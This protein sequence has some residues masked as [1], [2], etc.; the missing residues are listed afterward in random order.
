[1][2]LCSWSVAI[3]T[4]LPFVSNLYPSAPPGWS[5]GI[6]LTFTFPTSIVFLLYGVNSVN[7]FSHGRCCHSTGKYGLCCCPART[8]SSFF[9]GF[10]IA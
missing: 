2:S 10:C 4:A 5:V 7:S 8:V 1:M 9:V 6:Q 3:A